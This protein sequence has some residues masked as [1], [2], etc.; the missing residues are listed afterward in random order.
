MEKKMDRKEY[1][2]IISLQ[3]QILARKDFRDWLKDAEHLNIAN[4][5]VNFGTIGKESFNNDLEDVLWQ[6]SLQLKVL[7]EAQKTIYALWK[8]LTSKAQYYLENKKDIKN[9]DLLNYIKE[10]EGYLARDES[11]ESKE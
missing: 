11:K 4:P 5:V 8:T 7:A 6:M 3:K 2:E 1:E 10:Y 9:P